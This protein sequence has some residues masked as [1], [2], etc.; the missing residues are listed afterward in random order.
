V[1]YTV[2]DNTIV[3]S[4]ETKKLILRSGKDTATLTDTGQVKTADAAITAPRPQL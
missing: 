2:K 3:V 4:T 1:D